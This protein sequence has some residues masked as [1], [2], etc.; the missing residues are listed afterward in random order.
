[1]RIH[2]YMHSDPPQP[3]GNSQ[4][5]SINDPF[6]VLREIRELT[7]ILRAHIALHIDVLTEPSYLD[8]PR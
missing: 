5:P 3:V 8:N 6:S 4:Y 1:M 2:Q 7:Y